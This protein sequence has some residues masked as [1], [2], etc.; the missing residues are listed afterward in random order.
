MININ[1]I[2]KKY[3]IKKVTPQGVSGKI[4]F[5]KYE[6]GKIYSFIPI[7]EDTIVNIKK[8]DDKY[9]ID[10]HNAD[11]IITADVKGHKSKGEINSG[12]VG[13]KGIYVGLNM[14]V[15]PADIE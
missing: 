9:I 7:F 6:A 15:F 3:E 4:T 13:F 11:S 5:S 12:Y 8:E 14:L 1:V 2:T 10:V